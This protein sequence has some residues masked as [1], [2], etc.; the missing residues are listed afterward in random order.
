MDKEDINDIIARYLDG[1]IS[2]DEEEFLLEWLKADKKNRKL[3][4]EL[5]DIWLFSRVPLEKELVEQSFDKFAKRVRMNKV[6]PE[7]KGLHP[8]LRWVA[9]IAALLII[10]IGSFYLINH[11][12]K[13]RYVE[14]PQTYCKVIMPEKCKGTVVLPDSS[15]VWLNA[16]S[17]LIYP[18]RFAADSRNVKLT[19]EGYFEVKKNPSAPFHVEARQM[20]VTV[21]GTTFNVRSYENEEIVETVLLTGSVNV[22]MNDEKVYQLA[23]NQRIALNLKEQSVDITTVVG[24]DYNIWKE[25]R[26]RFENAPLGEVINKLEKWYGIEMACPEGLR[27]NVRLS[28]TVRNET[29]GEIMKMISLIVPVKY[30]IHPNQKV[31]IYMSDK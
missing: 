4:M 28:L 10:G 1:N 25:D 29:V 23:P 2:P 8:A 12:G 5:R 11:T 21:L 7:R 15:V 31:D 9:S 17:T 22:K 18:E 3:F 26:L 24:T 27:R 20:L 19:G 6:L 13:V 14:V 16:G 30:T